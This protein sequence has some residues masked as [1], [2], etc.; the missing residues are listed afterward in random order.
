MS[1]RAH[2]W[3]KHRNERGAA[4]VLAITALIVGLILRLALLRS[5]N[6]GF[7]SEASR[8]DVGRAKYMAESGVEYAAWQV[9]IND[10]SVPYTADVTLT[11]GSF[12]VTAADDGAREDDAVLITSTGTASGSAYTAKRVIKSDN[13]VYLPYDYAWCRNTNLSGISLLITITSGTRGM[14]AN[15]S[16]SLSNSGNNITTG[17][18][19]TGSITYGGT[20]TPRYPNS[21][22]V[23]FPTID[24]NYYRSV[25]N[26]IYESDHTFS[27]AELN[28]TQ[29]TLIFVNGL[30]NLPSTDITYTGMITIVATGTIA[31][32]VNISRANDN[33]YLALVSETGTTSGVSASSMCAILY[34]HNSG[35]TGR[36]WWKKSITV[37]GSLCSDINTVSGSAI[38]LQN[39]PRMTRDILAQMHLPGL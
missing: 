6:A 4:Y 7:L 16:I 11:G 36:V 26:V 33:S 28:V 27:N 25:A 14:H 9:E 34:S 35:N 30:A 31:W 39:D 13:V 8:V 5:S 23:Q 18:W 15:G 21:S 12:H 19:A 2:P 1:R 37:T 32:N 29:P 3:G 17:A 24:I 22:S 20:M 38:T 10:V